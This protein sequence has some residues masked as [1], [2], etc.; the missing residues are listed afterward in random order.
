MNVELDLL[1]ED[2]NGYCKG[3]VYDITWQYEDVVLHICKD[4]W[5]VTPDQVYMLDRDVVG[6]VCIYIKGK[7]SGYV[8]DYI[9]THMEKRVDE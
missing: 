6:Q 4:G 5:E 2:I 8:K 9:D 1:H 3:G 7:W